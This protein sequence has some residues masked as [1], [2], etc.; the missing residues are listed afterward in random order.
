MDTGVTPSP[1]KAR[2]TVRSRG[3]AVVIPN[4]NQSASDAISSS[5]ST[6]VRKNARKSTGTR[7]AATNSNQINQ[8]IT[9]R[10]RSSIEISQS[11]TLPLSQPSCSKDD[12]SPDSDIQPSR[13]RNSMQTSLNSTVPFS[14][15]GCSRDPDSSDS[16]TSPA[17]TQKILRR[18]SRIPASNTS[19]KVSAVEFSSSGPST[20]EDSE[21]EE[22]LK[23]KAEKKKKAESKAL[24][25]KTVNTSNMA[26]K[27]LINPSNLV[28][29]CVFYILG[30]NRSKK[31]IKRR[32][33][34]QHV[35]EGRNTQ[36]FPEIIKKA[37]FI[38]QKTFGFELMELKSSK[39]EYLLVN[40]LCHQYG[41]Q[42]FA[43]YS[44][45]DCQKQGFIFY[46]LTLIFMN[47][48]SIIEDHLWKALDPLG[49]EIKSRKPHPIFGDVQKFVTITLVKQMYLERRQL[50]KDPPQYELTWG[51]RAHKEVLKEDLLEFV[52]KIMPE[53]TP[54]EWILQ[55][56]DA[57]G[58]SP[59]GDAETE[60]E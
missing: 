45:M 12:D 15:P 55:Y 8:T 42:A 9:G 28:N 48:N 25:Q 32:D 6:P 56:K 31:A 36:M 7:N 1:R 14:Q 24:P 52:C 51:E 20:S 2:K 44:H 30:A 41:V 26:G 57:K 35:F 3:N 60:M 4:L 47:E 58:R 49:I 17:P 53:T 50:S 38:L 5:V 59:D 10:T 23:K 22:M 16:D 11:S 54:E 13:T 21:V 33:I 40:K 39:N 46:I 19:K 18:N 29:Q 34:I 43:E 27:S 37:A